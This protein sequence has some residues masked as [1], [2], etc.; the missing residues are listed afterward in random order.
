MRWER[1]PKGGGGQK[2]RAVGWSNVKC[3]Q[4]IVTG[5]LTSLSAEVGFIPSGS[6]TDTAAEDPELNSAQRAFVRQTALLSKDSEE[7]ARGEG[8]LDVRTPSP[9]LAPQRV[10]LGQTVG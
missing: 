2:G 1:T 3:T 10:L 4:D 9:N 6:S 7:H 8:E 5:K